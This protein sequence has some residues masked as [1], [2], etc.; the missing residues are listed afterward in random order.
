MLSTVRY[1]TGNPCTEVEGYR[2]FVI[3]TLPKLEVNIIKSLSILFI[4]QA[5]DGIDITP[6]ERETAKLEYESIR[7]KLIEDAKLPKD[8]TDLE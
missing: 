4:V 1:L 8:R 3:H 6:E 7:N 5:L 2:S